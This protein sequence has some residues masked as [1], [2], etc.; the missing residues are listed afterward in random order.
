MASS[1]DGYPVTCSPEEQQHRLSWERVRKAERQAPL[2]T[3]QADLR[4]D[5]VTK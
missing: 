5:R 4:F 2:K 1:G 3:Y